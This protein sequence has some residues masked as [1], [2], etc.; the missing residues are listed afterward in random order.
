V[1]LNLLLQFAALLLVPLILLGLAW[2]FWA[3]TPEDFAIAQW[4]RVAVFCALLAVSMN[5]L[6]FISDVIRFHIFNG[7]YANGVTEGSP[8]G[9][10]LV[11]IAIG[12][13]VFGRGRVAFT[14]FLAGLT[15]FGLWVAGAI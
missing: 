8:I 1:D 13:A 4:R 15:G 6:L 3:K 10:V 5:A 2:Y 7:R 12:G 11:L 9:G 14:V